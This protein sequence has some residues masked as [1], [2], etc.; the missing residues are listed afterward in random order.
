LPQVYEKIRDAA[1]KKG[2]SYDAAQTKA[3]KI[4]NY[5]R[6]KHPSMAKLSNKKGAA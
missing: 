5:L 2:M 1:V 4:Y 6:K 3:A